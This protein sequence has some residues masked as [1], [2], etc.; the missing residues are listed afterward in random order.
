MQANTKTSK[1]E[2]ALRGII[3][4]TAI[5]FS[6]FLYWFNT[7]T[8]KNALINTTGRS[9]EKATVVEIIK[10]NLAEDGNRYGNQQV[11]LKMNTGVDKGKTVVATSPDGMLFGAV[12]R[13]GMDVITISSVNGNDS[14]V[15]VY[16]RD[17]EWVVL[18]FAIIFLLLLSWIGGRSGIK[19]ALGLIFTF[20]CIFYLMIPMIYRGVSP[21]FAAVIVVFITTLVTMFLIGGWTAK[22]ACAVAGTLGGVVMAGISAWLFSICADINGYNV[23]E[24]ENLLF[25]AQNTPVRIGEL[26]F[27]GILISALGAVMDISISI[28]S[29]VNE[30]CEKKPDAATAELFHSGMTIGRDTMGTMC[31][32]L[33]LAFTGSSLGL[34]ILNYAYDLPYLQ[35]INSYNVGIEIMQGLSGTIGIIMTVPLVSMLS[36]III[37]KWHG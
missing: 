13:P 1:N 37:P 4:V 28:A 8:V 6:L 22:T 18:G 2:L 27:A 15:T 5:V 31:N 30:I 10:D 14:V 23:G 33:I 3:C 24:I 34:L 29:A 16:S 17:R 20:V 26:L 25:I 36:A 21:F 35:L 12:C 32:T 19:S 7:N 9:F 11:S